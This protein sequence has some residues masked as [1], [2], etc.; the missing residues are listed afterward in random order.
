MTVN[1]ED[2]GGQV[3]G[4]VARHRCAPPISRIDRAPLDDEGTAW[5]CDHCDRIWIARERAWGRPTTL[6]RLRLWWSS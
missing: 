6:E 5:R 1:R 2:T 4:S 3:V